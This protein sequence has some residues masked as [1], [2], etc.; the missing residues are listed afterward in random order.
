MLLLQK[1][2][3]DITIFFS[4]FLTSLLREQCLRIWAPDVAYQSLNSSMTS[5]MRVLGKLF[6]YSVPQ[7]VVVVALFCSFYLQSTI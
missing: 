7:F 5:W 3:E 1:G 6:N 4:G 2:R